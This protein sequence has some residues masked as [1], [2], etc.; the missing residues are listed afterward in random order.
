M[1]IFLRSTAS[2]DATLN[3]TKME[4]CEIIQK[5]VACFVLKCYLMLENFPVACASYWQQY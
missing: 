5:A 4:D 3:R 1:K 2:L